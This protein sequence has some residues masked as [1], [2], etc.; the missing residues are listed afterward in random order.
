M[1]LVSTVKLIRASSVSL[2]IVLLSQLYEMS[3]SCLGTVSLAIVPFDNG[4]LMM[5]LRTLEGAEK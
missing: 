5:V 4:A 1:R 3:V 2:Y